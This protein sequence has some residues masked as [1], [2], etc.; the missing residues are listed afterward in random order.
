MK[1]L[2]IFISFCIL[3]FLTIVFN[4]KAYAFNVGTHSDTMRVGFFYMPGYNEIMDN[5]VYSGYG[6]EMTEYISQLTSWDVEYVGYDKSLDELLA[7]LKKGEIDLITGVDYTRD[8]KRDFEVSNFDIGNAPYILSVRSNDERFYDNNY[9]EW[10]LITVGYYLYDD[11]V[12]QFMT[13]AE[14]N[15]IQYELKQFKYI[16]DC[17]YF[18]NESIDAFI[19]SGYRNV[20]FNNERIVGYFGEEYRYIIAQKGNVDLISEIDD[21]IETVLRYDPDLFSKLRKKYYKTDNGEAVKFTLEEREYI[22]NVSDETIT[23]IVYGELAPFYYYSGGEL[24]GIIP[25]YIARIKEVS[26]LNIEI[27]SYDNHNAYINAIKLGNAQ[28]C[29]DFVNLFNASTQYDVRMTQPYISYTSSVLTREGKRVNNNRIAILNPLQVSLEYNNDNVKGRELI[30]Y[31]EIEKCFESVLNNETEA[32]YIPAYSAK[33]YLDSN[34]YSNL[35]YEIM[36]N[37]PFSFS[38]AV[39]NE[40]DILLANILSKCIYYVGDAVIQEMLVAEIGNVSA[41]DLSFID[42]LRIHSWLAW[43]LAIAILLALAMF[44]ALLFRS[45]KHKQEALFLNQATEQYNSILA[46]NIMVIEMINHDNNVNFYSYR[47]DSSNSEQKVIR[48]QMNVEELRRL[49]SLIHPDDNVLIKDIIAADNFIEIIKSDR[50]IYKEIRVAYKE[51]DKNYYHIGL[52]VSYVNS[53]SGDKLLMLFKDIDSAKK[54]EE[55]KRYTLQMALDTARSYGNFRNTFLSQI[56]HDLRTPMNA[57]IGMTTIAQLNINDQN[58]VEECLDTISN[59]SNHLIALLN[60]ILD[61]TRIETG[62]FTFNQKRI[63][64]KRV[65]KNSI[66]MLTKRA[67]D[68]NIEL[69]VDDSNVIHDHILADE[70]RLEQIF[71]NLISNAIKYSDKDNKV[72]IFLKET[73]SSNDNEFYYEFVVKDYGI[74][75]SPETLENLYTPFERGEEAKFAEGTGLGMTITKSIIEAMGGIITVSSE[76]NKGTTFTVNLSFSDETINSLSSASE[77]AGK[78]ALVITAN[79]QV[80]DLLCAIF[81]EGNMKCVTMEEF[82]ISDIFIDNEFF[83]IATYF[84]ESIDE[85]GKKLSKIRNVVGKET[86]ICAVTDNDLKIVSSFVKEFRID[87]FVSLKNC[88]DELIR[89]ITDSIDSK[90]MSKKIKIESTLNGKRALIVED[91]DINAI[92]AKAISEMKG[93]TT[94]IATNG[95]EAIDMLESSADNYYDIVF[96]DLHMPVMDGFTAVSFIRHSGRN[97]LKKI[98]I[99]AM[100][101]NTFPE[102][103]LKCKKVGMNDYISKPID[104]NIFSEITEK[105]IKK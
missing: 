52:T 61:V 7:M 60:D 41:R 39:I 18:A 38:I 66:E 97:Y 102:D 19:S 20:N 72:E 24:T 30:Y 34:K 67:K 3:F 62:R 2:N 78:T 6:Y 27:V 51:D 68:N 1:R 73:T 40:K 37:D 87:G 33:A 32:A 74:G 55:E 65:L 56:T 26:G 11:I 103:I 54:D 82:E 29:L 12:K 92:F 101:A 44:V 58:K 83:I 50:N 46:T 42:F 16:P 13:F 31:S 23:G 59:S 98:P 76:L 48:E 93:L 8:I 53:P 17:D 90:K 89:L 49:V 91:V 105:Y 75:M 4:N 85:E 25:E 80:R 9:S 10:P 5:G 21:A 100:S 70:T 47:Y 88:K 77:V 28:L 64:I 22:N 15:N 35:K 86:I 69:I 99:I 43:L 95:K 63:R 84:D 36:S 14:A 94:E 57:I 45:Y 79:N 104:V 96:M 81:E 71:G